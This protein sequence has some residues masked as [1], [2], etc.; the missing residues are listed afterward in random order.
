MTKETENL[1]KSI[2]MKALN[3]Y[4]LQQTMKFL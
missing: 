4:S 1:L 3:S 2:G